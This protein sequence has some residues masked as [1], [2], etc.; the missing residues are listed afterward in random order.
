MATKKGKAAAKAP[1]AKV[2]KKVV[3]RATP[4]EQRMSLANGRIP[5]G[6][7][8]AGVMV[9]WEAD[10]LPA[11]RKAAE[12]A[13]LTYSA[14]IRGATHAALDGKIYKPAAHKKAIESA[15]KEKAAA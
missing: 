11:V 4:A 14:F 7:E 13:G 8:R 5:H 9:Q 15:L 12:E 1:K 6:V 2:A 10:K 3:K